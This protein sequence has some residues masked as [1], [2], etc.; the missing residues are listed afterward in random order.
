MLQLHE[1]IGHPLELDRIL[2]D[3]RNYAGTSFVTADMFRKYQYG[4]ELLNVV[5]EPDV[6]GELAS[7]AFDD[8]GARAEK[9][10]II[11]GGVLQR[12]LGSVISQH[13]LGVPGVACSRSSHWARPSLDRMANLNIEAGTS[14]LDELIASVED[15]VYMDMNRSWSIDDSRNKFQF[16]CEWGRRIVGGKLGEV[17]KSPSYRGVSA[18]FWQSLA[19]VGRERAILGTPHCGKA[20]PNQAIRVG[21]ATPHCLFR[22]VDVFGGAS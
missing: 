19:G 13:R 8:E 2:G 21:H 3:E 11:R 12:G 4:S 6:A 22:Q 1:S 10:Y 20:E 17:V 5:Y 9:S 15:G 18:N 14:S 16:G 7:Y